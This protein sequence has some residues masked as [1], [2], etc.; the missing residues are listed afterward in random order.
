MLSIDELDDSLRTHGDPVEKIVCA[1][2]SYYGNKHKTETIYNEDLFKLRSH[3]RI[4]W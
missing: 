4:G 1:E 3:T 2:L